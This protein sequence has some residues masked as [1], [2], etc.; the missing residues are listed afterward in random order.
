M[1]QVGQIAKFDKFVARLQD[2]PFSSITIL[3]HYSFEGF[4]A[5]TQPQ[6]EFKNYSSDWSFLL[7]DL[8]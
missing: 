8:T 2:L 1:C 6:A 7:K 5:N 3:S 4:P